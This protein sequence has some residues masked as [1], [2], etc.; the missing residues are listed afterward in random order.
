MKRWTGLL[1]PSSAFSPAGTSPL[2]P[3]PPSPSPTPCGAADDQGYARALAPR[4][5]HFPADHGPHPEFR[6]EW[7]YYTGNLA[8][9]EGRRFGFQLTFF[10][11]ALA[12]EM[13][14]RPPPGP[15]GRPGWPTS[16]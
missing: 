2:I 14:A 8:T 6:T 11:S 9:A 3:T 12:P 5:F 4:E 10:R 13:P 1:L 15:R 7:W 16:R